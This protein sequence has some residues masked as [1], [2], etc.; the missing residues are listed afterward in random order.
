MSA[1]VHTSRKSWMYTCKFLEIS[2][3]LTMEWIKL[4]KCFIY[5]YLKKIIVAQ[6][7]FND[8]PPEYKKK[9][10]FLPLHWESNSVRT[11]L[12]TA[13]C[14]NS[15]FLPY[16]TILLWLYLSSLCFC[17]DFH[18]TLYFGSNSRHPGW[19]QRSVVPQGQ[20]S[21]SCAL[22][23]QDHDPGQNIWAANHS[24]TDFHKVMT[25]L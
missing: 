24:E 10:T 5:N 17:P 20:H 13:G 23:R 8:F 6:L 21:A 12:S 2:V 3:N 22:N 25:V 9:P 7:S 19:T 1:C 16:C 14:C 4:N 11:H 15:L 18:F